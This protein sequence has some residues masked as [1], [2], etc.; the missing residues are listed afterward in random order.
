MEFFYYYNGSDIAQKAA[1]LK[2]FQNP[3]RITLTPP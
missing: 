2:I 3:N 1:I